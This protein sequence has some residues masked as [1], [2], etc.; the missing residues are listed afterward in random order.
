MSLSR[1]KKD[2]LTNYVSL[3]RIDS[4]IGSLIEHKR[5]LKSMR[6]GEEKN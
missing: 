4:K 6:E 1:N 2:V 5:G 3:L